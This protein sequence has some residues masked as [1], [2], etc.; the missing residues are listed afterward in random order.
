MERWFAVIGH[1]APSSGTLNLNDLAGSGGRM[2]VL[3]RAVNSALFVS[4]GIREDSH[5]LLHL[6]GGD[7]PSR[8][9]WFNGSSLG[10]VR[11]DER[12]ISGQIKAVLKEA[13]PPR[14]QFREYTSGIL[15]SGGDIRHT[16]EEWSDRGV[17]PVILD[18]D[19]GDFSDVPPSVDLGFI[20]SD[21]RPLT[22]QDTGSIQAPVSLSLGDRWLQGHSCIAILHYLLDGL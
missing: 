4:H 20:I 13:V 18:A 8:R 22:K 12:S 10:G 1:R 7:G 15:H 3:A 2:D 5:V 6:M 21:D 9:I 17:Y 16:I 19:G 14:G 11:P